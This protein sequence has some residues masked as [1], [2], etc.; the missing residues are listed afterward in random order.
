MI[1]LNIGCG[2]R[3]FGSNW[4]HIDGGD[5]DHLDYKDITKLEFE[6]DSVD[7]IYASHVL[8]YFDINEAKEVIREWKRV[9][10]PGGE[11]RVAVPDFEAMST[12]YHNGKVKLKDIIG[13]L[14]GRMPMGDKMIYHKTTYDYESL[15]LLLFVL[16]F[17]DIERYDWREYEVHKQNDDHSQAYLNPKGDKDKGTLISLNIKARK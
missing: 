7:L 17:H 5:Y 1:K 15:C 8:E 10:K 2:W 12:L 3:D 16:A 14:Y 4:I 13:P 11:L 9:L 6:D